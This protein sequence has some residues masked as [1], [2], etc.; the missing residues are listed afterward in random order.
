MFIPR[1]V[2][3]FLREGN[4]NLNRME[5][6]IR[7]ETQWKKTCQWC[8]YFTSYQDEYEDELEPPDFGRCG[9][10]ANSDKDECFGDGLTCDLF[11]RVGK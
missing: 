6:N 5:T 2:L 1:V 7:E 4:T 8:K 11:E 9:N 3:S 10:D